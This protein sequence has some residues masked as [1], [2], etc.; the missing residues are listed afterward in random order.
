M[1]DKALYV[2]DKFMNKFILNRS[3]LKSAK[4][5]I[6]I[7]S[8]IF[9]WGTLK[10]IKEKSNYLL[11]NE[12]DFLIKPNKVIVVN[13]WFNLRHMFYNHF[14]N[15]NKAYSDFIF[16]LIF[17][18]NTSTNNETLTTLKEMGVVHLMIVSGLHL[19]TIYVFVRMIFSKFD[20]YGILQII[21]LTIYFLFCKKSVSIIR[22]Y[23]FIL[24][25]HFWKIFKKDQELN[26]GCPIFVI[27][28]LFLSFRPYSVMNLGYWLSYILTIVMLNVDLNKFWKPKKWKQKAAN[29]FGGYFVPWFIS[30][31]IISAYIR[32]ISLISYVY[33]I[34]LTPIFQFLII[35]FTLTL[36]ITFIA[37][38][39]AELAQSF[40][41]LLSKA[42]VTYKFYYQFWYYIIYPF[43]YIYI[44]RLM[45]LKMKRLEKVRSSDFIKHRIAELEL[46]MEKL[47]YAN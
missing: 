6:T 16:P 15:K 44:S 10:E 33:S 32:E 22:T 43:I 34:I 38:P 28:F 9:I 17:G 36:P 29:F 24:V 19:G 1:S 39:F 31:S 18:I 5:Q 30:I 14:L 11:A 37:V 7:Y 3:E 41:Q 4:D 20:K 40:I 46:R 8:K 12:I 21:M 42:N 2:E 26:V 25:I 27:A 13:N 35:F 47:E 23:L 45:F